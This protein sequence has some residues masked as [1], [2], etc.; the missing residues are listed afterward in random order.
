MKKIE[1]SMAV[2]G[3]V[4]SGI[5]AGTANV[6]NDG[7]LR[8]LISRGHVS[9]DLNSGSLTVTSSITS[10]L[11]DYELI[12]TPITPTDFAAGCG[13]SVGNGCFAN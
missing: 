6:S 5:V 3:A 4:L 2:L 7:L 10:I 9:F 8:D 12:K 11:S 13:S 1:V